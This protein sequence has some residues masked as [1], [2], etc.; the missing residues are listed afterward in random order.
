M[1]QD[2]LWEAWMLL[3]Y[4]QISPILTEGERKKIGKLLTQLRAIGATPDELRARAKRY[5]QVMPKGCILTLAAL[6]N[7]WGRCEP[8]KS[9]PRQASYTPPPSVRATPEGYKHA[10]D[11]LPAHLRR[12]LEEKH[13]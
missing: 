4:S 5:P 1:K 9:S 13:K 2:L 8:M 7:N 3:A 11:L 10:L 6:V 12:R